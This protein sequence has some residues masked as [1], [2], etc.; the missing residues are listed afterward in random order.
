M[1][2]RIS[3]IYLYGRQVDKVREIRFDVD[4]LNIIT[5]ASATGKSAILQIIDYCLGSG[6]FHVPAGVI[7][8]NVERYAL[9]ID[10][11]QGY[12]VCAR[13][14][15]QQGRATTNVMHISPHDGSGPPAKTDLDPNS[16]LDAAVSYL[17]QLSGIEE[18]ITSNVGGSRREF[19]AT[20]RHAM[21]FTLQGQGEVANP[22][23]LFHSQNEEFIPQTIRDVIPFFLGTVDT[24]TVRKRERLRALRRELR[25]LRRRVSDEER[26]VGPSGRAS[27]LLAECQAAGLIGPSDA[28][29]GEADA[30]EILAAVASQPADDP[31]YD[32][33]ETGSV[34]DRLLSSRTGVRAELSQART[35]AS[36]LRALLAA[37]I[38]FNGEAT[39]QSAR[40]RTVDL[41]RQTDAGS[42][43]TC[44]LCRSTLEESI[45]AVSEI[46]EQ[47]QR[48]DSE[49]ADVRDNTPNLQSQI[50]NAESRV[51]DAG[52][53]LRQNQL[54]I[55]QVSA[56]QDR[57]SQLR[58]AALG[59]AAVR[60]RVSLFL[61]SLAPQVEQGFLG[62]RIADLESEE[63]SILEALD[64]DEAKARL[65][66]A[67]SRVSLH[68]N[69]VVADLE[70][71]YSGVPVRLDLRRLTVVVDTASGATTLSEL[72]SGANWLAYHLAALI[73]LHR[74]FREQNR[75]VPRFLVLDQPSQVYFP[76]DPTV[77]GQVSDEDTLAVERVFRALSDF[78]RSEYGI[79]II[80]VDHADL[81]AEWF[82][83]SV[84]ERFRGD[85]LIPLSW[86]E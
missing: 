23:I 37:Q 18:N 41:L 6:G 69:Q 72:G 1:T 29:S 14:E 71:E 2:F 50:A 36:N 44:P 83:E 19:S 25:D 68:M 70:T 30:I 76:Q 85:G 26:I 66:S 84:R 49:I 20:I 86:I 65:D 55:D 39:T 56:T 46:R 21:F 78:A 62:T 43:D 7:R 40:L 16:D 38:D 61:E 11:A 48:L 15:P 28:I 27:A 80:V 58:E 35:E 10:T 60:G 54:E 31:L 24:E 73:G 67:L 52:Q 13:D 53:R 3:A 77:E 12:F 4:D 82:A 47:L 57:I 51:Q 5:G 81:T 32:S 17:S 33:V 34:L 63:E 22:N 8:Q 74:F 79:Q 64:E 9:E 59:R 45:P 42:G 75:P